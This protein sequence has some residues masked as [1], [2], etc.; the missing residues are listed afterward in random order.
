MA[1]G[2]SVGSGQKAVFGGLVLI[3]VFPCDPWFKFRGGTPRREEIWQEYGGKGQGAGD[4]G[5]L[6]VRCAW[7]L[8]PGERAGVSPPVILV[9]GSLCLVLGSLFECGQGGVG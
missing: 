9:L 5:Q 4:R 3:R 1:R 2:L 6:S 7:C 8:V